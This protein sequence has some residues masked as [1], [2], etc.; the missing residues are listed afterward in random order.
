MKETSKVKNDP[1]YGGAIS[2]YGK[3][4]YVYGC[5]FIGNYVEV[6]TD[7]G[8]GEVCLNI[9]E[10]GAIYT[11][12]GAKVENCHF[13]KDTAHCRYS[14]NQINIYGNRCY[15]GAISIASGKSFIF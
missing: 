4:F 8:S 9:A 3:G 11:V 7:A 10:G 1:I 13:D 14:S 5:D 15:G 12:A 6:R 2:N